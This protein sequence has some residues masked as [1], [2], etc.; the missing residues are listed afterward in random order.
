MRGRWPR[1]G[2]PPS[3]SMAPRA[4]PR[5]S[6]SFSWVV[7]VLRADRGMAADARVRLGRGAVR[8][9]PSDA[10]ARGCVATAPDGSC[11]RSRSRSE[12]A[13]RRRHGHRHTVAPSQLESA[14]VVAHVAAPFPTSR[15]SQPKA[16]ASGHDGVSSR[17]R[18]RMSEDEA[19]R[20]RTRQDEAAGRSRAPP[21]TRPPHTRSGGQ[22]RPEG[23]APPLRC[24]PTGTCL[25]F[26]Q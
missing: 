13:W 3:A 4:R 11:S 17:R 5:I 25:R 23:P 9:P 18:T 16:E 26:L 20:G 8:W 10:R 6:F 1:A 14:Q 24:A 15:P 7:L 22:I 2:P 21:H 12:A 19:G